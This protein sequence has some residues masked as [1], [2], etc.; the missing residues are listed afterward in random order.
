MIVANPVDFPMPK[1]IKFY[2]DRHGSK[3]DFLRSF[4]PLLARLLLVSSQL[5]LRILVSSKLYFAQIY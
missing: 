4:L 1:V 2:L 5:S 3:E